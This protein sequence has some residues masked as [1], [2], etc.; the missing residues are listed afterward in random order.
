MIIDVGQG[1][2]PHLCSGLL[3]LLK[4]EPTSSSDED[5]EMQQ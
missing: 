4:N 1:H 5:H 3:S 2:N